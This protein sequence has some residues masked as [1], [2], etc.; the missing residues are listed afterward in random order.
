MADPNVLNYHLKSPR[1]HTST[2]HPRPSTKFT[3]CRQSKNTARTAY[4]PTNGNPGG[5]LP[6]GKRTSRFP[7]RSF[8]AA[9]R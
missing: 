9:S 5:K 3:A 1:W 7:A 8:S 4:P 2:Y 6:R